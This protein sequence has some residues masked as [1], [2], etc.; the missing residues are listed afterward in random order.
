M[1]KLLYTTAFLATLASL[2]AGAQAQEG[3]GYLSKDRFQVRVRAIDVIPDES[4]NVNIGG[5][6]DASNRV[7]PEIDLT[8]FFTNNIAAELIAAT[9]KHTVDYT[10]NVK[11]GDS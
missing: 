2:S 8:Y 5:K 7:T 3:T 11:L 6:V 1:K 4:S 9:S 10:G